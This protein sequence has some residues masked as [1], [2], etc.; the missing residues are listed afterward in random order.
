[1]L[2]TW[3]VNIAKSICDVY[4]MECAMN[5]E[6]RELNTRTP[7]VMALLV[8]EIGWWPRIV[9]IAS[10]CVWVSGRLPMTNTTRHYRKIVYIYNCWADCVRSRWFHHKF[11]YIWFMCFDLVKGSMRSHWFFVSN[12]FTNRA[13]HRIGML[14]VL[15]KNIY[16]LLECSCGNYLFQYFDIAY[17]L[18]FQV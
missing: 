9:S 16:L 18:Y 4:M 10:C 5:V 12:H 6:K 8:A 13:I 7:C 1:M 2:A 3:A 15:E 11:H 17:L 14:F